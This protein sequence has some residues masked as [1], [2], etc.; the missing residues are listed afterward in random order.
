M[1]SFATGALVLA[2]QALADNFAV[3]MA[4]STTYENY[5]HQADIA[6]AHKILLD[7]G[8]KAENIVNL[9]YDDIANNPL[10]FLPG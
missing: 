5:R 4:G 3:L 9:S 8:L 10:N 6:H 7:R 1:K 2:T